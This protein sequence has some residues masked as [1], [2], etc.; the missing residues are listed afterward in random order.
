MEISVREQTL[1]FN[2]KAIET[3]L[4]INF[5]GYTIQDK[6]DFVAEHHAK[7]VEATTQLMKEGYEEYVKENNDKL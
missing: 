4:N 5:K 6:E 3:F 1:N 2:V 7:R